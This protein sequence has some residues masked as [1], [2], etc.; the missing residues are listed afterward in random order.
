MIGTPTNPQNFRLKFILPTQNA[1]KVDG[2]ETEG[3]AKKQLAQQRPNPMGKHQFL[4][5]LL[6]IY[7]SYK[8][9]S[10]IAVSAQQLTQIETETQSQTLDRAWG[11]LWKNWRK[12]MEGPVG[13]RNSTEGPI[14]V[15]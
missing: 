1:G 12:R 11:L 7:Y 13:D 14:K 15:Y 9:E 10:A 5:L 4:T 8:Q 3:M 2:A 6:I